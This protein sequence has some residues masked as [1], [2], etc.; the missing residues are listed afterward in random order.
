M[1]DSIIITFVLI[2]GLIFGL[3][4]NVD[5]ELLNN[6]SSAVLMALILL[7]GIE[8]GIRKDFLSLLKKSGKTALLVPLSI[9]IGSLIGAYV[10]SFF[11]N[12]GY[13][14]SL[15][16]S[17]GFGWYSLSSVILA[18][19]YGPVMGAT[20][21]LS[22]ISREIFAIILIPIIA[23]KIGYLLAIAPAGATS[24]DTTL[25]VITYN[26][27][28]KTGVISFINGLVLSSLVPVIIA[29]IDKLI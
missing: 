20:A 15:L 7:I 2:L 4:I 5:G 23:K 17:S 16:I 26:T 18:G 8:I 22:N 29:T 28:E 10:V 19:S 9:V 3:F 21:F 24:M 27:D 1:K 11:I 25:P 6:I 12:L 14:E 13:K